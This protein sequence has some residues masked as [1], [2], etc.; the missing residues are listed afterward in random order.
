MG[1][2]KTE[3][4]HFSRV[5]PDGTPRVQMGLR[6]PPLRIARLAALACLPHGGGNAL[7]IIS[8]QDAS[9]DKHVCYRLHRDPASGDDVS[10]FSVRV[11]Q[12]FLN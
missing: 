3:K 6:S 2:G 1:F 4:D 5:E 11:R 9:L 7:D 8:L 10:G 12:V